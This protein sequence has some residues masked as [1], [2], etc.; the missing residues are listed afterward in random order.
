MYID[1]HVKIGG[2]KR[3]VRCKGREAALHRIDLSE[4]PF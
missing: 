4:F 1:C 2:G 3:N